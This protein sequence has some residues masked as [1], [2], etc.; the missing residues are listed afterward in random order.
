MDAGSF[1]H[2]YVRGDTYIEALSLTGAWRP[3]AALKTTPKSQRS[4]LE[5]WHLLWKQWV[6][7]VILLIRKAASTRR[8]IRYVRSVESHKSPSRLETMRTMLDASPPQKRDPVK[9]AV[10]TAQTTSA[11]N[12]TPKTTW[13]D[14][15]L[16]PDNNQ[17]II[18][19]YIPDP[20][21]GI[22]W[23]EE[24]QEV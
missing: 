6:H 7:D 24:Y 23:G 22:Q 9:P 10:D 21:L 17:L 15:D 16:V 5:K 4:V 18:G 13:D 11:A 1:L 3:L 12:N 19:G 2:H 20:V 8:T 14:F